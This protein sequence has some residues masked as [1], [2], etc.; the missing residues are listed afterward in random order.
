LA[1]DR[2][3]LLLVLS[4]LLGHNKYL[5]WLSFFLAIIINLLILIG[6]GHSDYLAPEVSQQP[7]LSLSLS[8]SGLKLTYTHVKQ[9]KSVTISLM[10]VHV[11]MAALILLVLLYTRAPST[12]AKRF[13]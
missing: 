3:L 1:N 12:N 13:L 10:I 8:L 6:Y 5:A 4:W 11:A 9:V 7:W 2:L